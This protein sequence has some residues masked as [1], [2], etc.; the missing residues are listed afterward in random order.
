MFKT[1]GPEVSLFPLEYEENDRL[2]QLNWYLQTYNGT[3]NPNLF[4]FQGRK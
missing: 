1:V 4:F 3:Y 2:L